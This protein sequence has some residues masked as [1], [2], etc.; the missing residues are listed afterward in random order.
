MRF[1]PAVRRPDGRPFPFLPLLLLLPLVLGGT[2]ALDSG[3][4][5]L[6]ALSP[7]DRQA[8]W[9]FLSPEAFQDPTTLQVVKAMGGT[10]RTRSQWLRA[11]SADMP[12][13]RLSALAALPGFLELT[14]VRRLGVPTPLQRG[15]GSGGSS[16]LPVSVADTVYGELGPILERLG[17][18][19]AHTLGFLGAGVRIGILDGTFRTDHAAFRQRPPVA[20]WDFVEEDGI[21]DPD[22]EDGPESS[23]HGTALWSLVAGE[24]PGTFRGGAPEAGVVL[25]R[26]RSTGPLSTADEDRWVA[27]LEWAESQGARVVLSGVGFRVFPGSAYTIEELNGDGTP[28]TRAADQAALRGVLVVAPMGNAGPAI[29]SLEAPADGDSVL[30]AGALNDAGFVASFSA[31]GPTGDG[32][33]KPELW[34]PGEEIPAASAGTEAGFAPATGTEFAGALLAAAAGLAVEAYPGRG[35]VGILEVLR[36][37]VPPDAGAW[38]GIPRVASAI[39]FPDGVTP[40]PLQAVDEEGRITNLTPQLQWNAPTLHPLG[41]P[42][43]FHLEFASDSLFRDV[44]QRDSVVGI[45][46]KRLAHPLPP[47]TRLFWR[48]EARS[49]QGI[50]QSTA[51]QGPFEVP[52]WVSLEVLNDPSGTQLTDPQ[53]EFQWKALD[54][55][56]PVGPFAFDL[57]IFLD[58]EEEVIQSHPGLEEDRL[59]LSEPLPFNQPLRWRVIARARE[60]SVDTVTSAGPFV[61][62]GGTKPPV[63]ILYQNFPNPFPNRE[64]GEVH[65]RIWFDLADD[66]SVELAVF[67]MRGRRIR[68]LIPGS[69][70]PP[71]ELPSGLYGR[72]EGLSPDPCLSFSWDGR[73]DG[74]GEVAAGVY[75]LR[76]RAGGVV[77]V[78]RVV[79]WP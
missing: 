56:A 9:I 47:R 77:D 12:R 53:P 18:P 31:R 46:A 44:L 70:C 75:L 49:T 62:T 64:M 8:V 69:G 55:A 37:S 27:G 61:V 16:D 5:S 76:L 34:A 26:V 36:N 67:D 79:F 6:P 3:A 57:E 13:D 4:P 32:R 19:S 2:E 17:I 52:S 42:V 78:R 65:T 24:H 43:T 20:V 74:G 11:L 40:L 1:R 15:E 54:L 29:G 25:A 51:A 68:R 72:E 30:A 60:G 23:S 73:D 28:A 14:P 48:V 21:V 71:V 45:F 50:R 33:E 38:A 35:S 10:I 59:H 66:A 58:R 22:P 41:L 7:P 63:T 39:L